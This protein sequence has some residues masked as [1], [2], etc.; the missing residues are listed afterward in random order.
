MNIKTIALC[1]ATALAGSS[2]PAP[3]HADET[4]F[5][6]IYTTE[7]IPKGHWEYE[8]WNTVRTG[9]AAGSYTSFDLRNEMEYGV[10]DNFSAAFYVNSSY[11]HTKNVPDPDDA[12]QNLE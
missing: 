3:A 12:T 1:A 5:G 9:K 8:Q 6:Y 2:C 10:S 7:S 4:P 11:L